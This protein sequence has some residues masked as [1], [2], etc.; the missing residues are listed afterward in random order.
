M[1]LRID[2]L[3]KATP[4]SSGPLPRKLSR[5]KVQEI[6]LK[7]SCPTPAD[8]SQR[9]KLLL[10]NG[11]Q[12]TAEEPEAFFCSIP[13]ADPLRL[14]PWLWTLQPWAEV[15]PGKDGLRSRIIKD[16]RDAQAAYQET[17][18]TDAFSNSSGM[19]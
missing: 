15:L 4:I 1:N 7:V 12:I 9:K 14:Y 18:S 8:Y 6:R 10:A 16:L 3:A 17:A 2:L 11:A 19:L 5:Q 13:S